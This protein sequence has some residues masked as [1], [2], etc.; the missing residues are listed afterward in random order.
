MPGAAQTVKLP[1]DHVIVD[2]RQQVFDVINDGEISFGV[3]AGNRNSVRD[4]LAAASLATVAPIEWC[5]SAGVS[6][7]T[8]WVPLCRDGGWDGNGLVAGAFG[9]ME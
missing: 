9:G 1:A 4:V 2:A 3:F 5:N 7:K 8:L 6:P